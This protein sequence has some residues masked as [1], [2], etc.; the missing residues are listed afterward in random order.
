MTAFLSMTKTDTIL[1]TALTKSNASDR[2]SKKVAVLYKKLLTNIIIPEKMD[3]CNCS[4]K[5]SLNM[6]E[7]DGAGWSSK[8]SQYVWK[9]E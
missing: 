4:V 1:Q 3:G 9:N 8:R 2:S 7:L 5:K 6:K